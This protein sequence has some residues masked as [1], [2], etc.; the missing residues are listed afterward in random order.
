M[1]NFFSWRKKLNVKKIAII[2]TIVLISVIMIVILFN[3]IE[4][5]KSIQEEI[6]IENS[7]PNSIFYGNND[8][9]I[10]LSKAYKLDQYDSKLDYIME[11]RSKDNLG[12]FISINDIINNKT[13]ESIVKADRQAFTK[14]FNSYS[15]LSDMR[16]LSVNDNLAYTYSFHYLDSNLNKPFYIQI[17]WLEI[18]D[19]YYVF[20]I[21]FPLD[22]LVI[23]SNVVTETLATFKIEI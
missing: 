4:K 20:D 11:L 14:N 22:D 23:Y 10:E 9:S 13:L 16:E 1:N 19:K 5:Y 7:K 18:N 21:E 6:A 8:I 3:I 2:S 12:I 17:V 15:N